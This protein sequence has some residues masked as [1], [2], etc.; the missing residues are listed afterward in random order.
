MN[1]ISD[2]KPK[3][4]LWKIRVKVIRLWKQYSAGGGELIEMVFRR[5]KVKFSHTVYSLKFK[6][7]MCFIYDAFVCFGFVG[8][9]NLCIG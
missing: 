6:Q 3:K 7:I 5:C 2:L 4:S 9:Q 1:F 8:R